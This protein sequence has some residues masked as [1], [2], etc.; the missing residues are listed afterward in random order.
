MYHI[1]SSHLYFGSPKGSPK[2]GARL[3]NM[4]RYSQ[5]HEKKYNMYWLMHDS[6]C[7]M[8]YIFRDFIYWECKLTS[9]LIVEIYNKL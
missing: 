1:G 2:Y 9:H 8:V 5:Q 6:E 7:N 3:A 4:I